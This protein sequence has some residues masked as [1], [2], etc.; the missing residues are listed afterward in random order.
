MSTLAREFFFFDSDEIRVLAVKNESLRKM[1][2]RKCE[3]PF[4]NSVGSILLH[5]HKTKNNDAGKGISEEQFMFWQKREKRF[6]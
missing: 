4:R 1:M 3:V 5:S 2:L 6:E